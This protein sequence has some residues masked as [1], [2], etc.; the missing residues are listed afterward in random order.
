MVIGKI[1]L[2]QLGIEPVFQK[3]LLAPSAGEE[4][5]LIFQTLGIDDIGALQL[6]FLEN[7]NLSP[8]LLIEAIGEPI[9]SYGLATPFP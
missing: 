7:Q 2:N 9:P 6:G 5:S 8:L 4:A 3:L 1:A